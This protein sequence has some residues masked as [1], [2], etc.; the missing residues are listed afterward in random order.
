MGLAVAVALVGGACDVASDRPSAP[1]AATSVPSSAHPALTGALTRIGAMT[2]PRAAHTASALPDGRVLIAGGCTRDS[3]EGITA[4][5]E[6]V[7]PATGASTPGPD[8][9]EPRV[10]H[11]AVTLADGR[12]LLIGGFGPGTVTGT[13][14]LF[15]PA[16]GTMAPGPDLIE[17]RADPV[18]I[19]LPNGA[20]LVA[21][22]YDGDR[23]MAS[24]ELLD[25]GATAFRPTGAMAVARSSHVGALLPDGRVLVM[26]GSTGGE[27]SQVRASAEVYDPGT[28]TWAA[29]D[30]LTVP[31]H[32]LAALGLADWRVLV[33]GGSDEQDAFGRYRSTELYDP[34]T[35][36]FRRAS[37]MGAPRYKITAAVVRL[38]D[39]RVLV[40]GGAPAA[41]LF[42]PATGTFTSV[43]GSGS[44][45]RSFIA[46]VLVQDGSVLV[47]GGYDESIELSDDVLRFVP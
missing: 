41:E 4:S 43:E 3:C 33:I 22:G 16:S 13:T 17:P 44:V 18:A 38:A 15:D 40:A 11:A 34:A 46:A 32:K 24:A 37:D 39:G 5:T 10:G 14:D 42:D 9:R 47:T 7:D 23:S 28:G 1:P 19:L 26:G 6:L 12:I 27:G 2:V 25:R 30:G 45:D 35:G 20:L 36:A 29:T 21:G 31:R 8:M